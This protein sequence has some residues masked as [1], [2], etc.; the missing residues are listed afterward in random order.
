MG[1]VYRTRQTF[2]QS[3]ATNALESMRT[4]VFDRVDEEVSERIASVI[5]DTAYSTIRMPFYDPAQ[6]GLRKVIGV[7]MSDMSIPD[8]CF[9][10]PANAG[11][12]LTNVD[13]ETPLTLWTY[14]YELSGDAEFLQIAANSIG[15]TANLEAELNIMGQ[16]RLPHSAFMLG[17]V[18]AMGSIQ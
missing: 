9:D 6:G 12:G 16:A 1:G 8:F 15:S 13:H 4:T 11:Y 2:E 14:A 18:Q 5:V 3:F 17:A 10:L 7:G